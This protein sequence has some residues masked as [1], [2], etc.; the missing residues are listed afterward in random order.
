M[1]NFTHLQPD[2]NGPIWDNTNICSTNVTCLARSK[3]K[4]RD[5]YKTIKDSLDNFHKPKVC[6]S[7]H[8]TCFHL[9][10]CLEENAT[11]S[12][13]SDCEGQTNTLRI[14]FLKSK[15]THS[16]GIPFFAWHENLNSFPNKVESCQEHSPDEVKQYSRH[17]KK[18]ECSSQNPK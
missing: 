15:T 14:I 8:K 16:L 11:Q 17:E 12:K 2:K 1:A 7:L 6:Y 10:C 18:R 13:H 3:T 5:L 4:N 9:S